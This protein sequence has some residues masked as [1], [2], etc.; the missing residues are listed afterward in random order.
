MT[1]RML[2]GDIMR[3]EVHVWQKSGS[4]LITEMLLSARFPPYFEGIRLEIP[5]HI[6]GHY[7]PMSYEK[8]PCSIVKFR[9]P[10]QL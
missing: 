1:V 5:E 7:E 8:F 6:Q 2:K 4:H 9:S 3:K 10:T